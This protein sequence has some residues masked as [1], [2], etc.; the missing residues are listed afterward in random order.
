MN[1]DLG[2]LDFSRIEASSSIPLFANRLCINQLFDSHLAVEHMKRSTKH[3]RQ[4][5]NFYTFQFYMPVL[6]SS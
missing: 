5:R 4:L 6:A 3:W 2:T 1:R